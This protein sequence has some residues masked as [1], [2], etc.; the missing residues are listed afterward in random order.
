[1]YYEDN[2]LHQSE[3]NIW[4]KLIKRDTFLE[5]IKSIDKYYLNQNMSLHE[6]GLILFILF[7]KAK[8]Y[9]FI[10]DYG[11][12]YYENEFSTMRNLKNKDRINKVTKDS[13]LYLEF[14]FNYTNDT[15]YEKNMAVFQ[16]RSLINGFNDIFLNTTQGFDYIYKVIDLYLGCK[17][18]SGEDKTFIRNIKSQFKKLEL[19][20]TH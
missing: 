13:F 4:G 14:M 20:L 5:G 16:F 19:N 6:D 15:L 7:K 2:I 11:L 17:I 3:F 8:S 1:M 18:I 10:N 9:L 12:L